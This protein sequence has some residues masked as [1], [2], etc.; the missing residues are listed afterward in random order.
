MKKASIFDIFH[1]IIT[2]LPFYAILL[3]FLFRNHLT[4]QITELTIS[5]L[6]SKC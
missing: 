5:L 6:I 2:L 4:S 1:L 3:L